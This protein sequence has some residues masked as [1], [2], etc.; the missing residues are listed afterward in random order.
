MYLLINLMCY[1]QQTSVMVSVALGWGV[2]SVY[3]TVHLF[4]A[5][6]RFLVL[7]IIVGVVSMSPLYG[8]CRL[9]A[10]GCVTWLQLLVPLSAW[11]LQKVFQTRLFLGPVVGGVVNGAL[12]LLHLLCLLLLYVDERLT[13]VKVILMPFYRMFQD[14]VAGNRAASVG[15]LLLH[16]LDD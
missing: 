3:Y 4:Y 7:Y 12:M 5:D 13:V 1:C 11:C 2:G 8:R 15:L 6:L 10:I 14:A 16:R 9:R